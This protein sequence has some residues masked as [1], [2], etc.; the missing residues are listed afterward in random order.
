MRTERPVVKK[1]ASRQRLLM[2]GERLVAFVGIMVAGVFLS[3]MAGSLWWALQAQRRVSQAANA[4]KVRVIGE[5]LARTAETLLT[6]NE[7]STLRTVI[8]EAGVKYNL[9]SCRIVLPNGQVIA[10]ADLLRINLLKVPSRW[11]GAAETY[12]ESSAGKKTSVRCPL[13]IQRRGQANL[14]ISATT[15]SGLLTDLE[16]QS[17]LGIIG[18]L[19]LIVLL[20]V[21][22]HC[23]VRL[24]AIGAVRQ[25][26][27]AASDGEKALGALEVS[28]KFGPEA[29][30]WNRILTEK[31]ELTEQLVLARAKES[32]QSGHAASGELGAACDALPH[33]LILVDSNKRVKYVNG[34]AAVLLQTQRDKIMGADLAEFIHDERILEPIQRAAAGPTHKRTIIEHQRDPSAGG[35]VLRYVIR[36]VR[37]EDSGVAMIIIEDI[38]Q[39]RVAEKARNEFLAQAAH[40]LRTPLSNIRLYVETALEEGLNDP[41]IQAKCFNVINEESGRLERIVSDILSVSEVEAGAFKLKKDDVRFQEI[42]SRLQAD[43]GPQAKEKHIEFT[44]QLP[45]KLPVMHGD[46]DKIT[47][48]LHNLIGNALKYTPEGGQV[49]VSASVDQSQIAFD[50]TDTGIG[51]SSEEIEKIFEKFYRAKNGRAVCETGSGLGLALAREVV[52]LHGGDIT[53]QSEPNQGSTFTLTL[54]IIQ[55]AA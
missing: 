40:E 55:E 14:E 28:P 20:L 22:R 19:S 27:L 54:P 17:G 31:K 46:R 16:A 23:R 47:L 26:L 15:T 44:F 7:V 41:A 50:V 8:A 30:A 42:L 25:A 3:A 18:A 35:G 37:R 9:D 5:S 51:V 32:F 2:R 4:E 13:V 1:P 29:A 48:A 21:Y 6:A 52:R 24:R 10:D 34:A 53:V 39:Q 36:P 33:G 11:S 43:Y 38:T 45:P 49:T 12:A